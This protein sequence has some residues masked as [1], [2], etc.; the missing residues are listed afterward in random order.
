MQAPTESDPLRE[1]VGV[2]GRAGSSSCPYHSEHI[3][4]LRL[5]DGCSDRFFE[6]AAGFCVGLMAEVERR[7]SFA[8]NGYSHHVQL[9]LCE[10]PRSRGEYALDLLT[11]GMALNLYACRAASTPRWAVEVARELGRLRHH[12]KWMKP[13]LDRARGALFKGFLDRTSA[14]ASGDKKCAGADLLHQLPALVAWMRATGEL[15][16]EA[17]RVDHWRSYLG[18]L[19]VSEA[20]RWIEVASDLFSDF[21]RKAADALGSYTR[22]VD[23][24]LATE[25]ANHGCREDQLFCGRA[26]VEYHLNMVAAEVMNQG[27]RKAFERT[28]RK[29]VLVPA[30]MR[31][32]RADTCK[33]RV[34]GVDITCAAC[35]PEC[36]VNYITRRMRKIGATVYLVPHTTGFGKWLDRWEREPGVGVTAV[37]CLLNIMPGGLEM[38]ERRIAAQCVPLDFPGCKKHW[39]SEGMS[40]AVNEDRLVQITATPLFT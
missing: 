37:A 39:D 40:T 29:V 18:T 24:F 23:G 22:G 16:Q 19:K 33:A 34:R 38:R 11:L 32:A 10:A 28:A 4:D 8:L 14:V 5:K 21:E 1:T 35:D 36:S 26:S 20:A 7:A 25:Y 6:D 13:A 31:G 2:V 12:A 30:C 15:E 17:M 9:N 27:L 3:Y